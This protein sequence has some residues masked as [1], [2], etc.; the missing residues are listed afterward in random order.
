MF[1]AE[2]DFGLWAYSADAEGPGG[3]EAL[4]LAA[5]LGNLKN[6]PEALALLP[7]VRPE[8]VISDI[9]MPDMDGF[10]LLA[11]LRAAGMAGEGAMPVIALTAFAQ[12]ED[13]LRALQAGFH[14]HLSKPV[15]PAELIAI[16]GLAAVQRK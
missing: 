7:R 3:R 8:L 6:G 15:E 5:P 11:Q 9:G 16:V 13:R 4:A 1:V 2:E 10:E 12:P 14:D